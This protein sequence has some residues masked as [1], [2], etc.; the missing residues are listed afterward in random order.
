MLVI[1]GLNSRNR[2]KFYNFGLLPIKK[3]FIAPEIEIRKLPDVRLP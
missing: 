3:P 1:I 2:L